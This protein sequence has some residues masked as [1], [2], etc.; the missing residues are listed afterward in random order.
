M[1]SV[2]HGLHHPHHGRG[3]QVQAMDEKVIT[4]YTDC[5]SLEE[6]VNQSGLHTVGDKRLAIDL[7]GVRQLIWR[8]LGEEVGDPLLTDRLPQNATTRLRW[9]ATAVMAADCLTKGMK[10][11]SLV[12]VM[13]GRWIDMTSEK[14]KQCESDH[15]KGLNN[16]G[17]ASDVHINPADRS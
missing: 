16:H 1:R 10:P 14:E 6:S 8:K 4:L 12:P 7:C 9:I 3:W 2:L 17:H 5:K 11:A 13:E 15:P